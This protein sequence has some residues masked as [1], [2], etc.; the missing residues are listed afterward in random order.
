MI[1]V[2]VIEL[3]AGCMSNSVGAGCTSDPADVAVFE[4]GAGCTRAPVGDDLRLFLG[5]C[6]ARLQCHQL[7][8]T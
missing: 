7:H 6:K 2:A 3:G 1:D 8:R 5:I 4:V